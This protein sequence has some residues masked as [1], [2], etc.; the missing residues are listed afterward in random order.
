MRR[1]S[2]GELFVRLVLDADERSS[3]GAA[4]LSKGSAEAGYNISVRE[5]LLEF[6]T[7]CEILVGNLAE[8]KR[9]AAEFWLTRPAFRM[10]IAYHEGDR[11]GPRRF[12]RTPSMGR[13][14]APASLAADA[15]R[16]MRSISS[17]TRGRGVIYP[18]ARV[19]IVEFLR[20]K[21]NVPNHHSTS[22]P[23]PLISLTLKVVRR[24]RGFVMLRF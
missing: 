21:V 5:H 15:K 20:E 6:Q 22:G 24:R 19:G 11:K 1:L 10:Q 14:A 2:V 12:L 18:C 23:R 13:E 7:L 16:S 9:L 3:A 8:A 4:F 17:A